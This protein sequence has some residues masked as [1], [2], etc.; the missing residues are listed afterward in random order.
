[1][2][3]AYG[4]GRDSRAFNTEVFYYLV[5]YLMAV[6]E[7]VRIAIN[8]LLDLLLEENHAGTWVIIGPQEDRQVM[9]G[10][11]LRPVIRRKIEI[12]TVK[13]MT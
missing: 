10:C 2:V 12:W 9:K 11:Y 1:M 3:H 6:R 13:N 5:A 7:Q 8:D 4:D